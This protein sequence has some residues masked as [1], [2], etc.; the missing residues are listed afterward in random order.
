[1]NLC[2]VLWIFNL[3]SYKPSLKLDFI[4]LALFLLM[5]NMLFKYFICIHIYYHKYFEE[6]I[7][8]TINSY[9]ILIIVKWNDTNLI[10]QKNL[11]HCLIEK[12]KVIGVWHI[13]MIDNHCVLKFEFINVVI[14]SESLWA[15][16]WLQKWK[17]ITYPQLKMSPLVVFILHSTY[18]NYNESFI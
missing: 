4:F 11:F 16:Q 9:D 5:N 3:I 13:C 17:R 7:C 10:F 2:D 15:Q 12:T 6:S 18:C 14:E 1:M 8:V